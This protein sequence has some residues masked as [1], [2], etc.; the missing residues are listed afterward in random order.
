MEDGHVWVGSRPRVRPRRHHRRCPGHALGF[1]LP[2]D[3]PER[4]ILESRG[5]RWVQAHRVEPRV[6]QGRLWEQEA[7][8]NM[9]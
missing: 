5:Y 9:G 2:Q 7:S 8:D 3:N 4:K 6:V 1:S